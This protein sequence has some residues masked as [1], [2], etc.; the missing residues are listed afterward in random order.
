[1]TMAHASMK[2]FRMCQSC[3]ITNNTSGS[4][5]YSDAQHD[6]LY[7]H[8]PKHASW[9]TSLA[10]LTLL[11][12][13]CHRARRVRQHVVCHTSQKDPA[14]S[15]GNEGVSKMWIKPIT[16]RGYLAVDDQSD[17]WIQCINSCRLQKCNGVCFDFWL[18]DDLLRNGWSR[19]STVLLCYW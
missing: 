13:D 17:I 14:V 8:N 18:L 10:N 5:H 2:C 15:P 12:D 1:M 7:P 19:G 16:V 4:I 3:E 11:L 6:A 9:F